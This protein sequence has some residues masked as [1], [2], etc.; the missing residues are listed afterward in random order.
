MGKSM[1][2]KLKNVMVIDP[3]VSAKSMPLLAESLR[4][5]V[6]ILRDPRTV[7]SEFV[8]P[9]GGSAGVKWALGDGVVTIGAA[10]KENQIAIGFSRKG[11]NAVRIT[12][13]VPEGMT[14]IQGARMAAAHV[15]SL[16]EMVETG[17]P[18]TEA[19]DMLDVFDGICR[20]C[21][22]IASME[23]MRPQ[24]VAVSLKGPGRF[25]ICE[26]VSFGDGERGEVRPS[27]AFYDLVRSELPELTVL[28][29]NNTSDMIFSISP[30][31]SWVKASPRSP[32][33]VLS[34]LA[35]IPEGWP[36]LVKWSPTK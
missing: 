1:K 8:L 7:E 20:A 13:P 29:R 36:H 16:I 9:K 23:D 28:K 14:P 5:A 3:N 10:K 11:R 18:Q 6:R 21:A 24:Q 26:E 19:Q 2:K 4:E 31:S 22:A 34:Q 35:I 17:M 25:T 15:E 30:V 32:I 12:H 33:E 27:R